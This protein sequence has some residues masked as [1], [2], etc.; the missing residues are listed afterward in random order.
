MLL[1]FWYEPFPFCIILVITVNNNAARTGGFC[2]D[3]AGGVMVQAFL[4]RAAWMEFDF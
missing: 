2:R 3:G 4:W 1:I